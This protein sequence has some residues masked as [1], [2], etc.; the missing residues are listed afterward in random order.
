MKKILIIFTFAFLL[1]TVPAYSGPDETVDGDIILGLKG[2]YST[3]MGYYS[4]EL[5]G[6]VY[7]GAYCIYN[8]PAI[9]K[10]FL[11]ELDFSFSAYPF[12]ESS[13]SYLYTFSLSAGPLA[14]YPIF[15][16]LKLYGGA[17]IRGSYFSLNAEKSDKKVQAFKP[18]FV[19]KGGFF[20][21]VRY[22]I[23]TRI[24]VEYGQT[25][26]SGKTFHSFDIIGGF[27][28]N[29]SAFM[30]WDDYEV[31][32]RKEDE[33]R[34]REENKARQIE[35]LYSR[36]TEAFSRG[37][38]AKAKESFTG[39]LALDPN[40]TKG[41]KQLLL[42]QRLERYY[43]KGKRLADGKRYFQAIPELEKAAKQMPRARRLL[44]QIRAALAEKV[45]R[46]EK[47]GVKAYENKKYKKCMAIM[48]QVLLIDPN[49]GTAGI[50]L[51]R[52]RKR[53]KA[54]QEIR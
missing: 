37:N 16:F 41:K 29:Y 10:Y 31:E 15:S 46:M 3:L 43:A 7:A 8:I 30:R 50:Y 44:N 23:C 42:I 20:I 53:Y 52:A 9:S 13:G 35:Q 4:S 38:F 51:P 19:G 36:G 45:A 1:F 25:W 54:L 2:G 48:R 26:L 12:T 6:S 22:G 34:E 11:G 40:H 28:F 21:P 24:G 17:S 27:S 18:G 32:E 5:R 39:L 47:Q 14:Y 49:N 33:T